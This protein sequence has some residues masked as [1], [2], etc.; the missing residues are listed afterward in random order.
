TVVMPSRRAVRATRT[1]TSPRFAIRSLA[2]MRAQGTSARAREPRRLYASRVRFRCLFL[3]SL[4]LLALGARRAAAD[5]ASALTRL[6]SIPSSERDAA[7]RELASSLS[8]SDA[9]LVLAAARAGSVEVRAR[10]SSA[11]ASDARHFALAAELAA[12]E[13]ALV[14]RTGAEALAGQ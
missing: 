14:A 7:E 6:G 4:A 9:P 13:D 8:A 1:A 10:I 2:N 5:V 11:L 12:S 3:A